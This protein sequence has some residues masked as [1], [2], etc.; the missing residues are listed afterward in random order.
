MADINN[1]KT[2]ASDT[3]ALLYSKPYIF[4]KKSA[5]DYF[6][7]ANDAGGYWVHGLWIAPVSPWGVYSWPWDLGVPGGALKDENGGWA[8]WGYVQDGQYKNLTS[9]MTQNFA[10]N[11]KGDYKVAI[12]VWFNTPNYTDESGVKYLDLGDHPIVITF[13]DDRF[14]DYIWVKQTGAVAEWSEDK[15]T[16]TIYRIPAASHIVFVSNNTDKTI[17]AVR[18][19]LHNVIA[20]VSG[21][22]YNYSAIK[23]EDP[24]SVECWDI[25]VGDTQV[26][27]KD[28]TY[29]NNLKKYGFAAEAMVALGGDFQDVL[30]RTVGDSTQVSEGAKS[31]ASAII[32]FP[33]FAYDSD[34]DTYWE[35]IKEYTVFRH[36][37]PRSELWNSVRDW[38]SSHYI[39]GSVLQ[40]KLFK[41]C[42]IT[43]DIVLN[44]NNYKVGT[45]SE[46][47]VNYWDCIELF[48][49]CSIQKVTINCDTDGE[50]RIGSFN[51]MFKGAGNLKEVY[52]TGHVG[53]AYDMSGTFEF[54]ESL[55]YIDPRLVDW[56]IR[57]SDTNNTL[58]STNMGY[59]YELCKSLVE[60]PS[61]NQTDRF[62][63]DNT[64]VFDPFSDQTF[65][66]C[67][68]LKK[69]GPVLDLR[70]VRAG[71]SNTCSKIFAG[72]T[73]LEDVRIKGLNHGN[74]YLDGT[75][76][77]VNQHGNLPL[78]NQESV[79][80]LFDNLVDLTARKE[81]NDTR[82]VNN[83][84]SAWNLHEN[85]FT[86]DKAFIL[87]RPSSLGSIK[88]AVS[89]SVEI[90]GLKAGDRLEF[91]K[92]GENTVSSDKSI[93][94]DGIYTISKE[95]T[96]D[97]WGFKLYNDQNLKHKTDVAITIQN[98][99]SSINP[100]VS[101][102]EL[103]CPS[104]WSDKITDAM[105]VAAN[106]KGWTIY[107]GGQIRG[108][109]TNGIGLMFKDGTVRD[110]N[111]ITN[112]ETF[113]S[114]DIEAITFEKYGLS[115]LISPIQT[116]CFFCGGQLK[117][118][119]I[120]FKY[121]NQCI[122]DTDGE[123][124]TAKLRAA[125]VNNQWAVNR[126]YNTII[127]GQ[128]CYVGALG[129]YNLIYQE[130]AIINDLLSKCGLPA[131]KQIWSSSFG[132][133]TEDGYLHVVY[134]LYDNGNKDGFNVQGNYFVLPITKY[135]KE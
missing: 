37:N 87:E 53:R 58:S 135:N 124:Q 22:S 16:V 54:C 46:P 71:I 93:T 27:H 67:V 65:N 117:C 79:T 132:A 9:G 111:Q 30:V 2:G 100:L 11:V 62:A 20:D 120:E 114:S 8:R 68:S 125:L 113:S 121:L 35:G 21:L 92:L 23:D 36:T 40:L 106:K 50:D 77:G 105:V 60:I 83:S 76:T 91:A 98:A 34:I 85:T 78:L 13:K 3:D 89:M 86:S 41:E 97:D 18:T 107:V 116:Q 6:K 28:K 10:E 56:S 102:A 104:Q 99:Y 52:M 127:D 134:G 126:A 69:I 108:G 101:S 63:V 48:Q 64:I 110:Y 59:T 72:C 112:S 129:E 122:P 38:F 12:T 39:A 119:T 128:H 131:L 57:H 33:I 61:Y 25:Y 115:L 94:A 31:K 19:D 118:D 80:Y 14:D 81:G 15:R 47:T 123:E 24:S 84:F 133:K 44:I 5:F 109:G 82:T 32:D 96:A 90:S 7:F 88:S 66:A 49:S 55:T 4:E 1:I 43:G 74:W 103:H 70:Q 51:Q 29:E 42:A 75:G 73:N 130:K 95:E 45:V 26:Y 17:A